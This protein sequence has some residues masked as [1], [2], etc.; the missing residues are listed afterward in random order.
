[1]RL[2]ESLRRNSLP[3]DDPSPSNRASA[4]PASRSKPDG[5]RRLLGRDMVSFVADA[6][7]VAREMTRRS[8]ATSSIRN[9]GSFAS[10]R[11]FSTWK[12]GLKW[13]IPV[14]R[15][16]SPA[17]PAEASSTSPRQAARP[18]ERAKGQTY[19]EHVT[20]VYDAWCGLIAEHAGSIDRIAVRCGVTVERLLQSS[21]ALHRLH[22]VGQANDE[23]PAN[24]DGRLMARH[25]STL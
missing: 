25:I 18:S 4:G 16:D 13:I 19:R 22:D 24:D 11:T 23:L 3:S 5:A 17:T 10:S 20:A 9:P 6:I 2:H 8:W 15:Y 7:E 1:M 14:H 12:D 21:L